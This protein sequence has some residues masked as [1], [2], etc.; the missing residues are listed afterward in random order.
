VPWRFGAKI[1]NKM[2]PKMKIL[3]LKCVAAFPEKRALNA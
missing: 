3:A 1:Q 2:A